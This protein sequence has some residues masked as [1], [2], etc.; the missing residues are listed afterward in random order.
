MVSPH[1][2]SQTSS[3]TPQFSKETPL[4]EQEAL[5]HDL[6]SLIQ[7]FRKLSVHLLSEVEKLSQKLKPE[8]LEIAVLVCEKFLYRKL[9]CTEELALLISAALQ[10]HLA[11]YAVSPIKIGLH[12]EDFS[13]LS[14]WL[15]LNDVPLLKNVEFIAD[16]LCKRASYKIELPSGILRQD[17][18]EELSHL[19]SVLTP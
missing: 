12:P 8:L 16:P 11:T 14:K 1:L 5:S 2:H 6:H 13:N 19:L 17:I 9:A 7:V 18:G 3:E 4:L 15:I 10:H